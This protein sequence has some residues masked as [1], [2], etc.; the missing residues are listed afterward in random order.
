M[1]E[2]LGRDFTEVPEGS[3]S[4]APSPPRALKRQRVADVVADS[5]DIDETHFSSDDDDDS[6]I[7]AAP[8]SS[9]PPP[10]TEKKILPKFGIDAS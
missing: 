7:P 1:G 6:A 4:A 8:L 3:T 9:R 10:R 2:Y 5:E